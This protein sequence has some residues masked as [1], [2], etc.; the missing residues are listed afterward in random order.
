MVTYLTRKAFFIHQ[1]IDF[2]QYPFTPS[3]S[4]IRWKRKGG[5]SPEMNS[6]IALEDGLVGGGLD[7]EVTSEEEGRTEEEANIR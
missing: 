5:G 6:D 7:E 3:P 4:L 2:I 1:L